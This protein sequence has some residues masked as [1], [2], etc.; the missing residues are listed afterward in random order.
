MNKFLLAAATLCV[1]MIFSS[2]RYI[3]PADSRI[4]YQAPALQ[5]SNDKGSLSLAQLRGEYV[6]VTFWA[7][8]QPQS[9]IDNVRYANVAKQTDAVTYV[10]VNLDHSDAM[11][12]QLV[13][14]DGLDAGSQFRIADSELNHYLRN[15][16]QNGEFCSF[17]IGPDGKVV[18]KNPTAESV[19]ALATR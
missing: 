19:M 2:A 16:R 6:L 13:T 4:G 11:L 7:S 3:V 15:W 17:L 1:L 10:G 18:A 9:R 12:D 8:N 5:V 14:V